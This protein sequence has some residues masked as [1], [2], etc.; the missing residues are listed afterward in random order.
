LHPKEEAR[1][2]V[3]NL[4]QHMGPSAYDIAW[5]ARLRDPLTGQAR[6]PDLIAWLLEHQRPDG[7]W[8]GE[9]VYYHDRIICTLAA[10]VAL[11]KSGVDREAEQAMRRA[12]RYLWHHLHL[13]TRDPFELSG[14]ELIFPVL[15]SEAHE[16]G[17]DVPTHTCG[18]GEMQT[19]KLRLIPPALLYSPHISTVYSLEFLGRLGDV[20]RLGQALASNGALGDSPAT[21]AYYL[22]LCDGRVDARALAY[23]EM[24][25]AKRRIVT[26]YPFRVFE[27][28]WV[29]NNLMF[30][31]LPVHEF[32]DAASLDALYA[33][34]TPEGAAL[35][36]SFGIADGD[37]TSVCCRVLRG[38]DY[39]VDPAILARF[40]DKT[41]HVFHTYDYE[42][43]ISM[44]TNIHALDALNMMPDYPDCRGVKKDI[45][46][47][48]LASRKY[49]V[50]WLDKWHASPY[51]TTAHALIALLREG[52]YLAHACQHTVDWMV[53]T[54]HEDGSWGFFQM[55]TV[56]ETAYALVALLH[57]HRFEPV[58]PEVL[59]RGVA[60]LARMHQGAA[61]TYPE[62]WLA[63]S[64]YAPYDVIR[65]SV[66]AALILYEEVMGR[67][68]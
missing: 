9:I 13:L 56:E 5:M 36:P 8:G 30:S 18:Y 7:S 23:L 27:L 38:A 44:S 21:T 26:V 29:L 39:A 12:E 62:L 59:H 42:R 57:Y 45:I 51:Y 54:Q 50:Y 17:L 32:A 20:N 46:I 60:Y 15:L 40:E 10:A 67:S 34:M 22:T 63:K 64:V 37:I 49:N 19:A 68:P 4:G 53:H 11:H 14:F 3:R 24:V 16:V 47:A 1:E 6:W 48:L 66:L 28:S 58:D 43:N 52:A 25:R 33:E 41:S 65:A 31:S 35:D 61:S 2:L 55:G